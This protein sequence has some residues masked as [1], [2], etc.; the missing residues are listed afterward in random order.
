MTITIC[1]TT[2]VSRNHKVFQVW[3][4]NH[5]LLQIKITVLTVQIATP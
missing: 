3:N 1:L 5:S 4:L 2:P